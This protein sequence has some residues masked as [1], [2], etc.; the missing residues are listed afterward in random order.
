MQA[1]ILV[2]ERAVERFVG[3]IL[4]GLPRIHQRGGDLRVGEPPQNGAGDELRPLVR[5]V[6]SQRTVEAHQLR[7]HLDDPAG[8]GHGR[9]TA[10]RGRGRRRGTC[11]PA[12]RQWR[13]VRSVLI[14][15]PSRCKKI[16][17]RR[18]PYRG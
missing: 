16:R 17:I 12:W 4:P 3:R 9:L 5:L 7:E 2:A 6:V 8:T 15:C 11:R 18:D 1:Q 10:T 14:L 13:C